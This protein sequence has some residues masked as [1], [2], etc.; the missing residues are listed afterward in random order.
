MLQAIIGLLPLLALGLALYLAILTMVTY[1]R[2][3]RPP[4]RTYAW[5]VSKGVPGDP[6]ELAAARRFE[7]FEHSRDGVVLKGWAID[8][9]LATGP[10][11]VLTHGWADSKVGALARVEA[12]AAFASRVIAWDLRGH[13]ESSGTCTLGLREKEDLR[14]LLDTLEES[15]PIVLFGWSLG[16]GISIAVATECDRVVGVIA[17]SPYRHPQTPAAN[18]LAARSMPWRLNLPLALWLVGFGAASRGWRGFDRREIASRLRVPLLVLHGDHDMVSPIE[19]GRAIADAGRG[20]FVPLESGHN[21]VWN[22]GGKAAAMRAVRD[23]LAGLP[24]A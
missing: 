16:A 20:T 7:R 6:G 17:E 10:V 23:F 12:V 22:S 8:G 15:A 13:G 21:D 19:D 9:D 4:R 2:L 1:V 18:V 24:V 5:A 14:T 11:I 3:T